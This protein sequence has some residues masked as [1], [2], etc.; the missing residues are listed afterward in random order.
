MA[1]SMTLTLSEDEIGVLITCLS[2]TREDIARQLANPPPAD[3]NDAKAAAE[4]KT[5]LEMMNAAITALANRLMTAPTTDS[6]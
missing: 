4:T 6:P 2:T 3:P 1:I 5:N